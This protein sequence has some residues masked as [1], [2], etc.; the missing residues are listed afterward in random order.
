MLEME[1]TAIESWL[2]RPTHH[3]TKGLQ[4]GCPSKQDNCKSHGCSINERDEAA[5]GQEG[6]VVSTEVT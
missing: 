5:G 2:L 3:L 1:I 6:L 4:C